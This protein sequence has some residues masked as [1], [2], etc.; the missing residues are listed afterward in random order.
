[1]YTH[2]VSVV[3]V[4]EEAMCNVFP[5]VFLLFTMTALVSLTMPLCLCHDPD[6]KGTWLREEKKTTLENRNMCY[7]MSILILAILYVC[8]HNKGA[9]VCVSV[10]TTIKPITLVSL[11][12]CST[13]NRVANGLKITGKFPETFHGKLS[14]MGNFG[15]I[16]IWKLN[17]NLGELKEINWK[18]G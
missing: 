15:N 7:V 18:F 16:P 14:C 11:E 13:K 4:T 5:G 3:T 9:S 8:K 6:N 10:S 12:P 1:M 2:Y 17:G